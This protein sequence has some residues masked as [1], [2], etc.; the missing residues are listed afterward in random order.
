MTSGAADV[1]ADGLSVD[2][3][4]GSGEELQAA[5]AASARQTTRIRADEK[6]VD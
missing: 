5:A 1:L 4:E 3:E 2:E 6:T